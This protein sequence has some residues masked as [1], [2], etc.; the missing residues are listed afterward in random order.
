MK[1]KLLSIIF[2]FSILF[3]NAQVGIGNTSPKAQLDITASNIAAP[4]ATD[5]I[6]IP[7]VTAFPTTVGVDQN[8]M[9]IFL[10]TTF[11]ANK[12]GLY[13]YDFPSTTWKWIA[14]GNN[15]GPWVNNNSSVRIDVPFQSDGITARPFGNEAVILDTGNVGFGTLTPARHFQVNRDINAGT[16]FAVT[17]ANT[18]AASFSQITAESTGCTAYLYSIN[19]SYVFDP[20][21]PWYK[22]AN[23]L[24]QGTGTGGLSLGATNTSG[25]I[26]FFTGGNDESM[27]IASNGNVG[28]G[29][30]NPIGPLHI[31]GS[32]ASVTLDR[33]GNSS[34]FVGRS[35]N[36]T[37]LLPTALI[38]NDIATRLS[39]WGYNGSSYLPVGVIDIMAEENQTATTAGGFIKFTTTNI[40]GTASS[41]KMRINSI[42]NVGIGTTTP[43]EK[44]EITNGGIRV[45]SS[46]GIGFAEI[47]RNGNVTGNDAAK[48]YYD[49]N[50]FAL[51][52]DALIIE[53]TDGNDLVPDGGIIFTNKGSNNVRVPSITIRGTGNLGIATTTPSEKLDVVGNIKLSGAIMPNNIAG[54]VGQ[55]LTSAGAG[56]APTWS[57]P[58]SQLLSYTTTGATT[59]IF[60]VTLSQYTIRVFNAVSEV[61][62][63]SAVG[64]NGKIFIIIG[65]NG[66]STKTWSTF[67]GVIYDDV[68]NI[69]YN[70]INSNQRFMVQSDGTDWIVIGR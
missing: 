19:Q 61:K 43:T 70:T 56:V 46:Q 22:G 32:S 26:N 66:I 49:I 60:N 47:P 44:L 15:I 53:K 41:E 37:Q 39:G 58:S 57:N 36:G 11:G 50:A 59:G 12:V 29:T 13:Y 18:G 20:T 25:I 5:G 31:S 48:M 42:G 63:P 65:S 52:Q 14:S 28:I 34:H 4:T 30:N 54:T 51:N 68:T 64:S 8:G 23:M 16:K 21:Y 38:T 9:I 27:R 40:G 33:F 67:G 6:L 24:L 45:N 2:I 69:T 62:L 55:V 35:A 3:S 10:T 17:N 7:R 1:S